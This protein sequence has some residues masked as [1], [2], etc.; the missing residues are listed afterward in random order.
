VEKINGNRAVVI[1]SS[2]VAPNILHKKIRKLDSQISKMR[3]ILKFL[4]YF[5]DKGYF[6]LK[7]KIEKKDLQ[8]KETRLKL[9]GF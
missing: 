9:K 3:N 6:L 7:A 4:V 2:P 1:G 8:R 5:E